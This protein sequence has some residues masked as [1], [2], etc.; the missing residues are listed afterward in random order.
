MEPSIMSDYTTACSKQA[1]ESNYAAG[2]QQ[3]S[4]LI[5]EQRDNTGR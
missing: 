3:L 1:A 4:V 2:Y 5:L